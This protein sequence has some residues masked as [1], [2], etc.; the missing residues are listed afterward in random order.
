MDVQDYRKVLVKAWGS[1][2]PDT[3][4]RASD[5]VFGSKPQPIDHSNE[6]KSRIL[7]PSM[8]SSRS[9]SSES[10]SPPAQDTSSK[11]NCKG[12]LIAYLKRMLMGR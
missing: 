4:K 2:H 1:I 7:E 5:E 10:V 12:G 3:A 9:N 8:A 11:G 6:V